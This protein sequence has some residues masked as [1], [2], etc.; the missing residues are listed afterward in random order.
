MVLFPF[1]QFKLIDKCKYITKTNDYVDLILSWANVAT[2][3]IKGK[4]DIGCTYNK[5]I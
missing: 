5:V 3:E 4:N 1:Q 2:T